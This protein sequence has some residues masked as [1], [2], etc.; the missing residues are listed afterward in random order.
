[1]TTIL[2]GDGDYE[3]FQLLSAAIEERGGDPVVWDMTDWPSDIPVTYDLG[4]ETVTVGDEYQLD[5]VTGVFPCPHQI[6]R[7]YL[8]RFA[9][10]FDDHDVTRLWFQVGQWR[11][12]FSSLISIFE[13]HGATVFYPPGS[14]FYDES[15]PLQLEQFARDGVTVPETVFATDPD[16][17]REFV[18]EH[19]DVV[20]KAVAWGGPPERLTVADLED[21][22]LERLGNAPVQFQAY[23]PGD[24]VRAFFLDGEIVAA[25]RYVTDGW[26]VKADDPIDDA[27]RMDLRA[28]VRTDIERVARLSPMRFGAADLRVSENSHVVLEVNPCPRFAF[29]DHNGATDIAGR[30]ADQ[31][32]D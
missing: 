31:L 12:I 18:R 29:H 24:D 8:T 30:L 21:A 6:F 19:E 16:R 7:L 27:V 23:H 22:P 2:I 10:E 25:S 5:E 3:E 13:R 20:C 9:E 14:Q 15:K 28:E 1:M 11:G 26:S 4:G 32:V 17:A